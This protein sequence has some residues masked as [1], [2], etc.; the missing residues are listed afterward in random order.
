MRC[1][2]EQV[3]IHPAEPRPRQLMPFDETQNRVV[4]GSVDG[5]QRPEE[6]Q[7]FVAIAQSSQ[8]QFSDHERMA[9]DTPLFQLRLQ[10]G[11]RSPQVIDPDRGID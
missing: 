10:L 2:S 7:D 9:E 8:R 6:I 4:G 1:R 5:W 3:H 11:I